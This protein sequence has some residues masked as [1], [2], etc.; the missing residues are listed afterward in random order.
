[1]DEMK[2]YTPHVKQGSGL[3]NI[4]RGAR[5]HP[6]FEKRAACQGQDKEAEPPEAVAWKRPPQRERK[7]RNKAPAQGKEK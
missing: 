3:I 2:L 4:R 7:E 5:E 1:M 6:L